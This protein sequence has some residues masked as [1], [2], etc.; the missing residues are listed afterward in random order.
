MDISF[1]AFKVYSE[2]SE[3]W[4]KEKSAQG[5][6]EIVLYVC[7]PTIQGNLRFRTEMS[8]EVFENRH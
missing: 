7:G 6:K 2:G 8:P 5:T 4:L 1:I 3:I